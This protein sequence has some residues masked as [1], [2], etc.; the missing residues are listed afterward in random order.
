MTRD[1]APRHLQVVGGIGEGDKKVKPLL[2]Y[3]RNVDL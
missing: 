2:S 1:D 3:L